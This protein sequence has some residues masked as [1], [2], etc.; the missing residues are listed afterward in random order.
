MVSS[1]VASVRYAAEV[2]TDFAAGALNTSNPLSLVGYNITSLF[3]HEDAYGVGE[4]AGIAVGL[5]TSQN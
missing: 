1:T 2:T 4:V 3:G 5:L